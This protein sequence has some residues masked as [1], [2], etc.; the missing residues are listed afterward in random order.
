VVGVE[1]NIPS[2]VNHC[3]VTASHPGYAYAGTP[4]M[5]CG[6]TFSISLPPL[7]WIVVVVYLDSF[8]IFKSQRCQLCNACSDFTA[9]LRGG[10]DPSA[11]TT[12]MV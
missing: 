12:V 9:M 2:T 7:L 6:Y 8:S 1:P 5:P 10:V 3:N 4:I 11:V